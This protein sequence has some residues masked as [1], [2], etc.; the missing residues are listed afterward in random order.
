MTTMK[1]K[2]PK[3]STKKPPLA[4][5]APSESTA[6]VADEAPRCAL[7]ESPAGPAEDTILCPACEETDAAGRNA[8]PVMLADPGPSEGPLAED[9]RLRLSL[10]SEPNATA[11][12]PAVTTPTPTRGQGKSAQLGRLLVRWLRDQQRRGGLLSPSQEADIVALAREAARA[13]AQ[14]L[15]A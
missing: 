8:A 4:P 11:D 6:P 12:R 5:V 7:C 14:E 9:G 2:T 15:E 1:K 13:A 10:D 3:R